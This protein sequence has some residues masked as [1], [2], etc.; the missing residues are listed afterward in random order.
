MESPEKPTTAEDVAHWFATSSPETSAHV[1]VDQN[2]V[3]RCVDGE[4]A[5]TTSVP[6]DQCRGDPAPAAATLRLPM[7]TSA[8][9][10]A[11][12]GVREVRSP[13]SRKRVRQDD[14]LCCFAW[15]T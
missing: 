14:P 6:R 7:T 11:S 9:V 13:G 8:Q 5:I 1:C 2:S 12:H 10:I 4:A 3:V 15:P